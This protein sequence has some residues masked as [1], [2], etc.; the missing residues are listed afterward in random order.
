MG[1]KSRPA[2]LSR[3]DVQRLRDADAFLTDSL[4]RCLEALQDEEGETE[5]F[6]AA[7]LEGL[8]SDSCSCCLYPPA[9]HS[10]PKEG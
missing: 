4:L 10:F 2:L 1:R 6:V 7:V 8:M 9:G 5:P 3:D